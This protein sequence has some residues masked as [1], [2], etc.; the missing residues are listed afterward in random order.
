MEPTNDTHGEQC[1]LATSHDDLCHDC[2]RFAQYAHE[3]DPY[4][5]DDW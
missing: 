3:D 5:K 2:W 1:D 4:D